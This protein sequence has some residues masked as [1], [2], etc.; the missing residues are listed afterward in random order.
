MSVQLSYIDIHHVDQVTFVK[1]VRSGIMKFVYIR[2]CT[3]GWPQGP[4]C[5]VKNLTPNRALAYVNKLHQGRW[6]DDAVYDSMYAA[7]ND[8]LALCESENWGDLGS[9]RDGESQS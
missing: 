7:V 3:Y 6:I 9:L 5:R 4:R 1:S 8:L 2:I